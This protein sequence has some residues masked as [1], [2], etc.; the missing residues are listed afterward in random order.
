MPTVDTVPVISKL[1]TFCGCPGRLEPVGENLVESCWVWW[2]D[3]GL[4]RDPERPASSSLLDLA[5]D[6]AELYHRRC[7]LELSEVPGSALEVMWLE[8][9]ADNSLLV[10]L[11]SVSHPGYA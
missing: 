7:A 4:L 11:K 6:V 3:G 1:V 9:T 2:T 8:L 5:C 10:F